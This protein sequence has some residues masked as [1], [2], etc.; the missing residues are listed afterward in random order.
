MILTKKFDFA[1]RARG[2]A[3]FALAFLGTYLAKPGRDPRHP[4]LPPEPV[5]R[6]EFED[7]RQGIRHDLAEISV[8]LRPVSDREFVLRYDSA[9]ETSGS[10]WMIVMNRKDGE[11]VPLF[12]LTE[13][14]DAGRYELRDVG[15]VTGDRIPERERHLPDYWGT[16]ED[17]RTWL[18]RK[19][20]LEGYL[21]PHERAAAVKE[22][23][24]KDIRTYLQAQADQT[25]LDENRFGVETGTQAP[26]MVGAELR[27][28]Y[29]EL[30]AADPELRGLL[31]SP[32]A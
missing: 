15:M 2:I 6:P 19:L 4:E 21:L 32:E 14:R 27:D 17:C 30:L 12:M 22:V 20:V 24:R 31:G 9:P 7:L 5:Q 25:R 28:L 26:P 8:A 13:S 3:A 1:T 10:N 16:P 29:A 11:S 18:R 23:S